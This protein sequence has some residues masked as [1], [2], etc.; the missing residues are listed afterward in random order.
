MERP[1]LFRTGLSEGV[2]S[3]IG[4][5]VASCSRRDHLKQRVIE[6]L[7]FRNE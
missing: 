1:L 6:S 5:R 2:G 3:F 4:D 7:K